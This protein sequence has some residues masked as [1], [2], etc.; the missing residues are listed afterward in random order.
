MAPHNPY[1]IVPSRAQACWLLALFLS[2]C[3][4]A[5]SMSTRSDIPSAPLV[6]N[7][8]YITLTS[9]PCPT[10]LRI[11]TKAAESEPQL[12]ASRGLSLESTVAGLAV[13]DLDLDS[14]IAR[15]AGGTADLR[16]WER[17][18]LGEAAAGTA[19][20]EVRAGDGTSSS[21]W[22]VGPLPTADSLWS[23]EEEDSVQECLGGVTLRHESDVLTSTDSGRGGAQAK[24]LSSTASLQ[25]AEAASAPAAEGMV[26]T[27]GNVIAAAG[28]GP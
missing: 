10:A 13:E 26:Q 22:S 4:S 5:S 23:D 2:R 20:A 3:M 16:P 11:C 12:V 14:L 6:L 21:L 15:L 9:R 24:L 17:Q 28:N 8:L 27:P 7:T 19:G 25:V 18:S 1:S